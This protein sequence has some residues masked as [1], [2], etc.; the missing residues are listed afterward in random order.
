M[1]C[2]FGSGGFGSRDY[3]QMGRGGQKQHQTPAY[4][5]APMGY[6]FHQGG[7][8]GGSYGGTYPQQATHSATSQDWWGN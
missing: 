3:R 8:Y 4:G 7:S 2:R 1:L 6:G 5:A